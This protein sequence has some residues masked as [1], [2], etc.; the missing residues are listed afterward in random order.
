MWQFNVLVTMTHDGRYGHLLEELSNYGE[1]HKTGF[2]GVVLGQVP[3]LE[4]FFE[5]IRHRRGEQ[6][7]AFQDLA[8]VVPLERVFT[9]ETDDF[10]AKLCMA[11]RPWIAR[12]AESRFH[13]RLERRGLKGQIIS[14]DI[15][16]AL[17]AYILDE[18]IELGH[19]A[20]IDYDDPDAV[21]AIETIGDRCGAGLITR[22]L[23]DRYD[24]VRVD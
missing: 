1:F 19:S 16:Q 17:D 13:V 3:A 10:L 4:E 2:Y 24:F 9:F 6:C 8:R 22:A 12:L 18:L 7:I 20:S 5:T 21:V 14:P 15:E 23:K 11:L